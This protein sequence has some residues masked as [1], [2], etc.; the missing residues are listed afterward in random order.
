MLFPEFLEAICRFIDKLSPIPNGQEKTKWDI[1]RRHNQTL[2][3]KL[4]T[5]LPFLINLIKDKYK[6]V[7]DKFALP[8]K[9]KETGKYII[10]YE[11]TLI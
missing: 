5:I 11:L 10:D 1:N 2:L 7:R 8:Q 4:E 3:K 9:D 6:N